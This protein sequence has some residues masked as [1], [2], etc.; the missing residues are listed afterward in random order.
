M[1]SFV[2]RRPSHVVA[3]LQQDSS[4]DLNLLDRLNLLPTSHKMSTIELEL[5][6][7]VKYTQP[8]GL[9]INNEYTQATGEEFEVVDPA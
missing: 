9:F 2:L 5:P 1:R 6:N 3:A 8:L 4:L 7:G